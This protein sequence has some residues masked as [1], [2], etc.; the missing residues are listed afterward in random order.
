M[1]KQVK[2]TEEVLNIKTD[3]QIMAIIKERYD[4]AGGSKFAVFRTLFIEGYKV[5]DVF[6]MLE[7]KK[8][9]EKLIYQHVRNEYQRFSKQQG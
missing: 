7:G 9:F 5:K 2:K 1:T 8:G 3:E 4:T 6:K